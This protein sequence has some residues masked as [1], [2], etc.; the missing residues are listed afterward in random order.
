MNASPEKAGPAGPMVGPFRLPSARYQAVFAGR[1]TFHGPLF[2]LWVAYLPDAGRRAGVVVSKRTFRR[3]VDRNRA[4]RLLREAFRLSRHRIAPEAA[5]ILVARAGIAG[6]SCQ[7]VMQD[8]E[9][10]C[11]RAG[12]WRARQSA[13]R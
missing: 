6:R 8:F 1:R 5:V 7:E 10:V 9:R 11:R 13:E 12:L 4:K 3:A 2:A